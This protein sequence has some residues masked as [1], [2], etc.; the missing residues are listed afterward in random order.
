[1]LKVLVFSKDRPLQLQAYLESMFALG[2]VYTPSVSVILPDKTDYEPLIERYEDIDWVF[3]SEHGGGFDLTLRE[4]TSEVLDD[5]DFVLFGCDDV[6]FT[7]PFNVNFAPAFL[8]Q[9]KN[10][11]G[12]SLRLGHNIQPG[13]PVQDLGILMYWRWPGM[14]SHWG[15]PFEL[16]AS[17][18]RA[19]LLKEILDNT[20]DQIQCPN[21]LESFG[22][23]HVMRTKAESHPYMSMFRS[24]SSAVAQDVNRVQHHFQN[25][26]NGDNFQDAEYLKTLYKQGKRLEWGNLFGIEPPDCFVGNRYWKVL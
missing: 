7:R 6:V 3:E 10:V 11:L 21:H 2:G 17:V 26:Y 4:Y 14:P 22:V 20:K 24:A 15:Y 13:I 5:D 25:R 19:S 1:M 23:T 18:Y 9:E 16:M 12:F 8:T